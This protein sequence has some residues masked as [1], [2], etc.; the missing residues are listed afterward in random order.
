LW[1]LG[2]KEEAVT[3]WTDALQRNSQLVLTNN[4]LAGAARA[5]GKPDEAGLYEKQADLFTP[6][7]PLFHWVLGR[8]LRDLGMTELADKHFQQAGGG[9]ASGG[10][11]NNH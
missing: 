4:E 2:R 3:V 1:L 5:A 8:R 9:N 11:P 7:N 10:I 6:N